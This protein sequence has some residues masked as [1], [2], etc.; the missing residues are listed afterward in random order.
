MSNYENEAP[1]GEAYDNSYVSRPGKKD[2]AV[3]VQSDQD[4][5]R[6]PID[7]RTADSDEQ[8]G[9]I[10]PCPHVSHSYSCYFPTPISA[11]R[12]LHM[13]THIPNDQSAMIR[14]PLMSRTSWMIVPAARSRRRA[15][16][17]SRATKRVCRGRRTVLAPSKSGPGN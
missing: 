9:M 15:D 3:P 2:E 7:E 13:L 5:V 1:S 4:T 14:K 16:I 6:D 17:A 11:Q 8:L 10:N 12:R